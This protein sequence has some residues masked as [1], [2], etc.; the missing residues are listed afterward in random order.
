MEEKRQIFIGIDIGG[1]YIKYS[2]IFPDTRILYSN[3][4]MT[5]NYSNQHQFLDF[6]RKII[7]SCEQKAFEEGFNVFGLGI[8]IPGYPDDEGIVKIIPNIPYLINIP[9]RKKLELDNKKIPFIFENDGN[10]AAFGEYFYGQKEK[11]KNIFVLTLGTGIGS[12]VIVDGKILRGKDKISG[13]LGHITLDPNGPVCACGKRGCIES[14]FS[15][16]AFI[17]IL[18]DMKIKNKKS[19]LYKYNI[20]EIDSIIIENEAR[21][22]DEVAK[23]IFKYS[24]TMLGIG[25]SVIVNSFNPEK[26][27]LAGGISNASDFFMNYMLEGLKNNV[28]SQFADSI[29]IEISKFNKNLVIMGLLGLASQKKRGNFLLKNLST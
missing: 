17:N 10:A 8:A 24:G 16:H 28:H 20:K 12:G 11:F 3:Y 19:S 25:L 7:H 22:G 15:H 1:T 29:N 2:I 23:Y 13:E 21:N 5:K 27:I 4:Q 9:L 6:I 26:I 14:Y 18:K